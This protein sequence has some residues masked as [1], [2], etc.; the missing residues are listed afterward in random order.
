MGVPVL[1]VPVPGAAVSPGNRICSL[2]TAP[3]L[4]VMAGLVLAVFVPSV[5]LLAVRVQLPTVRKVT[6][7][8]LVPATSAALAGRIGFGAEEVIPAISVTVLTTFQLASTAFTVTLK[9]VPAACAV[10]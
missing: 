2:A 1:P 10:G 4:T 9:E 6:L 3:A 8:T 5:M 7:K